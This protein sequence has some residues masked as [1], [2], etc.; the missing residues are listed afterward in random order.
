[1][2]RAIAKRGIR[3]FGI[4]FELLRILGVG[5]VLSVLRE[6]Y[7]IPIRNTKFQWYRGIPAEVLFWDKYFRTKG[8]K[9]HVNYENRIDPTFPLQDHV[10]ELLPQR[11]EIYILDVGAGPITVLGKKCAGKSIHITA[12]D[13]LADEY[14][15]ILRHYQIEPPVK[16]HKLDAEKLTTHFA[17]NTFDLVY[18]CNSIDH[19]YN[20]EQAI[21]EMVSVVKPGCYVLLEHAVDEGESERYSGLHQ[22]NFSIN[23]DREFIIRSRNSKINMTRKFAKLFSTTSE[24]EQVI[25]ADS[26]ERKIWLTTTMRKI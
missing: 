1:L 15:K 25:V 5:G 26:R 17:P 9:W 12:V 2:R 24:T 8:L 19:S 23:P 13:A 21:L 14:D 11:S 7:V 10:R 16:T 20:P 3:V 4:P 18:A 6:G 22:W